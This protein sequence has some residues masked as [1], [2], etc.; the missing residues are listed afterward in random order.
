MSLLE[1]RAPDKADREAFQGF[2]C[3]EPPRPRSAAE[4]TYRERHDRWWELEVQSW[5][6]AMRPPERAPGKRLLS[7][8]SA[9]QLKAVALYEEADGLDQ[10]LLEVMAV[11]SDCRMVG[12]GYADEMFN[13]VL[14]RITETCRSAGVDET[15]ISG[16]IYEHNRASQ[17]MARRM[18]FSHLDDAGEGVQVWGRFLPIGGAQDDLDDGWASS[19]TR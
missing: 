2:A 7:G 3:T 11:S 5:V 16:R 18:G 13:E 10:I 9:G 15:F 19:R 12:G 1:W 17:K 8:W 4:P 6:R 14:D